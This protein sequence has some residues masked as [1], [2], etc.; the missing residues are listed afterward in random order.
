MC[1]H[2]G[3][4]FADIPDGC[5]ATF[6]TNKGVFTG[7]VIHNYGGSIVIEQNGVDIICVSIS[8]IYGWGIKGKEN[9]DAFKI[10][11]SKKN[12]ELKHFLNKMNEMQ[13]ET[14]G[15]EK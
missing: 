14:K 6:T 12:A 7:K 8:D 3:C 5:S 10:N 9:I 13:N 15:E 4:C 11:L 2:A 1:E